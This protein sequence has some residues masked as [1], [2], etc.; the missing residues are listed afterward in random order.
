MLL[1][2][3]Y[4]LNA[5]SETARTPDR[6]WVFKGPE[7]PKK[8]KV[9]S[10]PSGYAGVQSGEFSTAFGSG[11]SALVDDPNKK[12]SK[13]FQTSAT[14]APQL[15]AIGN[16]AMTG[17]Q[18]NLNYLQRS[19]EEQVGWLTSGNDPFYNV[20]AERARQAQL[21]AV[22]RQ[23]VNAQMGGLNNSTTFGSALGRIAN[24]D[25]L[26]QNQMLLAALEYGNNNAR[27][28]GQFNLS[29]ISG[30]NGLMTPY[31]AAAA[32]QLQTAK[33]SQDQAA[34][35]TAAA[36]NQAE[37]A[38]AQAMN[39]YNASKPGTNWGSVGGLIGGG[40]ALAAA[41][42]T[43]GASLS[44]LPAAMGAGS[45]AGGLFGGGGGGGGSYGA[46]PGYGGGGGAPS[47]PVGGSTDANYLSG[48]FGDGGFG[49]AEM[50]V[51]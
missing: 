11:K 15:A 24:E 36:Q 18:D 33:S 20:M 31:G 32:S 28:N 8:A 4:L 29:T 44:F 26:R 23:R 1:T 40:L 6:L 30:L 2:P 5:K 10:T 51:M 16:T 38:Q 42:F 12:G 7:K 21:E 14:L 49:G 47:N 22:G 9:V 46:I 35:A 45:M 39:Q 13:I 41:P 17:A 27:T 50:A 3:E 37:L 19:P 48:F 43:G 25:M 34:A